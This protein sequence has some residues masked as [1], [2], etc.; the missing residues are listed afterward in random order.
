MKITQ[1]ILDDIKGKYV[2][3]DT[4]NGHTTSGRTLDVDDDNIKILVAGMVNGASKNR[5]K[6]S[7]ISSADISQITITP[8]E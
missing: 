5:G 1:S 3:I 6:V 7:Y 4:T 2:S 8:E